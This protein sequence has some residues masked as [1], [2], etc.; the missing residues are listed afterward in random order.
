[1]SV[2]LFLY[3]LEYMKYE[4]NNNVDEYT[5]WEFPEYVLFF[6]YV[7]EVLSIYYEINDCM[8]V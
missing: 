7:N 3:I 6:F 2:L 1:M 5:Y 8:L 4:Q